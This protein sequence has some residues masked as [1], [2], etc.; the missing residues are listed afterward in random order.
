[1]SRKV[2]NSVI[3]TL[4]LLCFTCQV[5]IVENI[6]IPSSD[7]SST[8]FIRNSLIIQGR[9][10]Q[11]YVSHNPISIDGDADFA[12]QAAAERWPG[13]GTRTNPYIISGLNITGPIN[14]QLISI[15]N[16]RV[17][18][19]ISN[20]LLTRGR[21]GIA[22]DNVYYGYLANNILS[23]NDWDGIHLSRSRENF[24]VNN[25]FFHNRLRSIWFTRDS[26][27]NSLIAN[28]MDKGL[29]IHADSLKTYVQTLVANNTV[30]GRPL[31]YW[32]NQAGGTV[33]ANA[34]Q[35]I[36]VN[37]STITIIRQN[38]SS[39]CVNILVAFSSHV[40]IQKNVLSDGRIGICL[41]CSK[42]CTLSGNILSRNGFGISLINS[43]S[44]YIV[45]NT[46]HD[47]S[48]TGI[49]CHAGNNIFLNNSII[50][51]K[52]K[53]ISV[54]YSGSNLNTIMFNDFIDNG[55]KY[56]YPQAGEDG[57]NNSYYAYNYW[58]NRISPD[59]NSDGIVDIPKNIGNS[60]Y[61]NPGTKDYYPQTTPNNPVLIHYISKPVSLSPK[62]GTTLYGTT[63][64]TVSWRPSIDYWHN[65][66]SYLVSF[67][68][69][70][71]STWTNFAEGLNNTSIVWNNPDL[72][73]STDYQLKIVAMC[74]EGLTTEF[75]VKNLIYLPRAHPPIF[76]NGNKDFIATAQN[77][78]W[79]GDGT[80]QNPYLID[81]L[82]ITHPSKDLFTIK[83][84][85]LHF[86]MNNCYLIVY[87][88]PSGLLPQPETFTLYFDNV[89]NAII[90]NTMIC[91]SFNGMK[92]IRC[93]NITFKN[94]IFQTHAYGIT[95]D[96]SYNIHTINNSVSQVYFSAIT[97]KSSKTCIISGNNITNTHSSG[98]FLD[99]T[100]STIIRM[101][102]VSANAQYGIHLQAT[103]GTIIN[104]NL[105]TNNGYYGLYLEVNV[106]NTQIRYNDF[107]QN[108]LNDSTQAYDAGLNNI[109]SH[110]YWADWVEP[111][112]NQ[113]GIV[114]LPYIISGPINNQDQYP[115]V[116]PIRLIVPEI[117]S[118][119]SLKI[120][121]TTSS[122]QTDTSNTVPFFQI[123]N[124]GIILSF[125]AVLMMIIRRRLIT[126]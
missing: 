1:M 109:F 106:M 52:W 16:T 94:S 76:I 105:F 59:N 69:D 47:G 120:S 70:S 62:H 30:N 11:Y 121:L 37:C 32:Q 9:I 2:G 95:I 124:A 92:L 116:S 8:S 117:P 45:N 101:N 104:Q 35:V 57:R 111:D 29:Y 34:G 123:S 31:V 51:N 44:N 100:E 113:D 122:T 42:N 86:L 79:Q 115:L 3:I 55:Y 50:N 118:T 15:E 68:P 26:S 61:G 6:S 27:N 78:G 98:I 7:K 38:I 110:N 96:S 5:F 125:V 75:I 81:N 48:D 22:L 112:T 97:L 36:I 39:E 63:P 28:R 12:T 65:N 18:F 114:D 77:K 40:N 19:N 89:S 25:S 24:L 56:S 14:K 82:N 87:P 72:P 17:Y 46:I 21:Q 83:N 66:L 43:G 99:S 102:N 4:L 88:D 54:Y 58:N 107:W 67:S 60:L 13:I 23:Y 103:N 119:T 93:A 10:T 108:N 85:D 20:C 80:V 74:P 73:E 41:F 64:I 49:Q 91:K 126:N 53:G 33:P 71:G 84:T 90:T